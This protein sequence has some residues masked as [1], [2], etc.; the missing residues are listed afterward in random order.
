MKRQPR[1][2][3]RFEVGQVVIWKVGRTI[4]RPLLITH[5][6]W[7]LKGSSGREQWIYCDDEPIYVWESQ[8]RPLT[9][10]ERGP[11]EK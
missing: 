8:L 11:G 7:R 6:E 2:K 10:K 4:I 3:E 1:P 9:R 5:R